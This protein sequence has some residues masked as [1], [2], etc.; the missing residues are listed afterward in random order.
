MNIESEPELPLEIQLKL[1]K[2]KLEI[3]EFKLEDLQELFMSLARESY[4][5]EIQYQQFIKQA[6]ESEQT[7]YRALDSLEK[8]CTSCRERLFKLQFPDNHE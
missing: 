7:C 5:K 3:R 2:W 1:A 8:E 6:L 4:K